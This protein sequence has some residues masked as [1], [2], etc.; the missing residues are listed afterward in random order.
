[1][2]PHPELKSRLLNPSPPFLGLVLAAV[3]R[4]DEFNSGT[5]KQK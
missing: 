4:L 3:G 1:M 5:F 2:Q